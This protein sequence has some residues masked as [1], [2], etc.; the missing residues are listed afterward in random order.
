MWNIYQPEEDQRT[1]KQEYTK[2]MEMESF[3][4]QVNKTTR[5]HIKERITLC[6]NTKKHTIRG[7]HHS[8][9]N[10]LSTN[11]RR[12]QKIWTK[13]QCSTNL[14]KQQD[15]AQQYHQRRADKGRTTVILDRDQYE[16][17]IKQM[18]EDKTSY[19]ILKKFQRKKKKTTG[20]NY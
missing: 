11:Q 3:T 10:G 19:P 12:R 13:K 7:S 16:Q 8:K 17:Q 20:K 18:L 14:K 5:K 1:G 2:T 6:N 4:T 9:R 15:K